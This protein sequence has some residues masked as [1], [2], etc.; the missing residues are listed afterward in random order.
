MVA[1]S[2]PSIQN[3][4]DCCDWGN[5]NATELAESDRGFLAERKVGWKLVGA[6]A[7]EERLIVMLTTSRNLS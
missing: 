2:T 7:T 1:L 3:W 4:V 5:S 6:S